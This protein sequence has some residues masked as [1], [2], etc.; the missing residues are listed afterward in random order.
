VTHLALRLDEQ[1]TRPDRVADGALPVLLG[2]VDFL[3][4]L[5]RDRREVAPLVSY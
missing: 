3:A 1:L 5:G 2:L 4:D